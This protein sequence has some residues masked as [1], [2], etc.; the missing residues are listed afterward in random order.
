MRPLGSGGAQAPRVP[1][2]SQG[3]ELAEQAPTSLADRS[4]KRQCR[5]RGAAPTLQAAT[6]AWPAWPQLLA[7]GGGRRAGPPHAQARGSLFS[8]LDSVLGF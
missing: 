7:V 8:L 5:P 3:L 1:C 2:P 4:R 6:T